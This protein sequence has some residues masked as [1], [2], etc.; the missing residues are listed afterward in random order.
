MKSPRVPCA[1]RSAP[2]IAARIAGF[3]LDRLQPQPNNSFTK[4]RRRITRF[5]DL[6]IEAQA[7]M[8]LRNPA[9]GNVVCRCETVTEAEIAE[10]L[11]RKPSAANLD[12]TKRRTRAQMGRCQGGF[13]TEKLLSILS[14]EQRVDERAITK[15]G[16]GSNM[17]L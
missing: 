9:Y 17:L 2:A 14:R 5:K 8:I 3:V 13:C 4:Y 15:N 10:A 7:E 1:M 12:P 6:P 16:A 11:S